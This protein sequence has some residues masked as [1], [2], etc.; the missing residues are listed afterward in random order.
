[1]IGSEKGKRSRE[2]LKVGG[3]VLSS[4]NGAMDN[5][6]KGHSCP[7]QYMTSLSEHVPS[8]VPSLDSLS[9]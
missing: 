7:S 2:D 1:M 8:S 9:K 3:G 6:K 4:S 5:G